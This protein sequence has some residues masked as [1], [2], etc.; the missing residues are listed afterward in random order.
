MIDGIGI[1]QLLWYFVIALLFAGFLFLEGID[2]GVGM[3]TR[4][5]ARDGDERAMYMRAVAPHWDGNEV[6]LITA[7]GA[8]FAAFPLWYASLFSGYY[9]L[10]FLVLVG[11]ILRG[12]SFEFSNH[13]ITDRERDIW[14]WANFVGSVLPPFFLGMMLTSLIQGIPMG[15]GSVAFKNGKAIGDASNAVPGFFDVCNLLSIVGGVAVVFFCFVHG[16]HFLSLKLSKSDSHHMLN[17]SSKVYWI[18]YPALVVFVILVFFFTDFYQKRTI[19]SL[20]ITVIIL[21]A[22]ICGHVAARH[23]RGGYAFIASGVTLAAVIAFIFNGLFPRVMISKDGTADL[24]IKDAA[25][26][27]VTSKAMTIVLCCLLPI[28]LAYFIWSYYIQRKRLYTDET[29]AEEKKAIAEYGV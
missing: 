20:V 5:I 1:L 6:W 18:A 9:I 23:E 12:V 16:L 11:L 25:A 28:M 14:Q 13:A 4:L 3:A 24:L 21:A 29:T 22:V 7:G 10:L 17:A 2:F 26:S 15:A 27:P 19:S 8:M